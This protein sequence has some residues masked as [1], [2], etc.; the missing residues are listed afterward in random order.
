[1]TLLFTLLLCTRLRVVSP[2]STHHDYL[3]KKVRSISN[4]AGISQPTTTTKQSILFSTQDALV[5]NAVDLEGCLGMMTRSR[6]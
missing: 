5:L 1:M 6:V 3:L 2:D 4:P